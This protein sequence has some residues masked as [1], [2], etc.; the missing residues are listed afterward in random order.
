MNQSEAVDQVYEK[1]ADRWANLGAEDEGLPFRRTGNG[2]ESLGVDVCTLPPGGLPQTRN[3]EVLIIPAPIEE[4]DTLWTYSLTERFLSPN[5]Y[6]VGQIPATWAEW[7]TDG[8]PVY[9]IEEFIKDTEVRVGA[10]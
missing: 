1:L 2:E 7:N 9:R 10:Y 5:P 8:N 4:P 3:L 6:E